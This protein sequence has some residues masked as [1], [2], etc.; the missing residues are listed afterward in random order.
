MSSSLADWLMKAVYQ[1]LL[2][3][4]WID[5]LLENVKTLFVDLYGGQGK[6]RNTSVVDCPFDD[7]F[8]QQLKELEGSGQ[9]TAGDAPRV[10]VSKAPLPAELENEST[11]GGLEEKEEGQQIINNQ[12]TSL[13]SAN[14][15]RQ[16]LLWQIMRL[17]QIQEEGQLHLVTIS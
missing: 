12:R 8:D 2:Q 11:A 9:S 14:N 17:H 7:Y 13:G 4:S 5:K 16:N 10:T 6:R 1:S 3:L 15:P